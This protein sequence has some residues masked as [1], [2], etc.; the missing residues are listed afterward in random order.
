MLKLQR[1][2]PASAEHAQREFVSVYHAHFDFVWRILRRLGVP[3]DQLEDAAQDVFLVL[4]RRLPEL[5]PD[6][7]LRSWLFGTARRVA[8]D[9]RRG[10]R[11][12]ARRVQ[13]FAVAHDH[14]PRER[15]GERTEA[16]DFV[17]RFLD[18]LDP[19]KR[20]VFVLADLEGFTAP[21]IAAALDVKL[22]TVYSRLRAA[23]AEFERTI[24]EVGELEGRQ[25]AW[26]R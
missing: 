12:H 16:V 3:F 20:M 1:P 22:N 11:R 4:H 9:F 19:D 24:A 10:L 7:S 14:P 23:R 21:E 8:A 13:A 25:V 6:V 26:N 5:A 18:R 15:I 17:Q 2:P